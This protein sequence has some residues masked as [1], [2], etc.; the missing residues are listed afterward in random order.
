MDSL[1][2]KPPTSELVFETI[3]DL[4]DGGRKA[5]TQ[6]TITVWE[7]DIVLSVWDHQ[8]EDGDIISLYLN[9]ELVLNNYLLT[10]N[11]KLIRLFL[12]AD[13]INE[14]KLFAENLGQVSP[15]TA[16][17]QIIQKGK[18]YNVVLRSDMI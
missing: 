4:E 15:N 3:M 7:T 6:H 17:M 14:L 11:K 16:S 10:K 1:C 13:E 18:I 5:E 2:G 12:E 8:K 9:N